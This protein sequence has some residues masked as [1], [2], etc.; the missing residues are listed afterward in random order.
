MLL[1]K[2]VRPEANQG[3]NQADISLVNNRQ[4]AKDLRIKHS[5]HPL[6]YYTNR[7]KCAVAIHLPL[8]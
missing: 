1:G 5:S 8:D 4:K 3:Q 7:R 2:I 6:L